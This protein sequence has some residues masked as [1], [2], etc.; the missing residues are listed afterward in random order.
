MGVL[1]SVNYLGK[2][3]YWTRERVEAGLRLAL[4][5]IRGPLPCGEDRYNRLKKGRHDWPCTKRVYEFYGCLGRAWLAIGAA[6]RRVD[7]SNQDWLPEE[8]SYLQDFAGS[9][10]LEQIG[11]DLCRSYASVRARLN[12]VLGITAKGNQGFWSAAEL[13][14]HYDC[15]LHRVCDLLRKGYIQG[16]YDKVRH[17]WQVDPA[18]INPSMEKML[19]HPPGTHKAWVKDKGD[20]RIRAGIRR[21]RGKQYFTT[22]E[23]AD[24]CGCTTGRI[25]YYR[26][27]GVLK[28]KRRA[29]GKGRP[30]VIEVGQIPDNIMEA[31]RG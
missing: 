10:T 5:Q 7:L 21:V 16:R 14:K 12:R 6:R 2:R 18:A 26:H 17:R 19:K 29:R 31:L 30:W 28:G 9:L 11:K 8:D 3:R 13:A 27:K 22:A 15:S 24:L 23:L 25:L 4:K 1:R 20:Y